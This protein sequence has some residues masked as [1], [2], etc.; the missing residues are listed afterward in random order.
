MAIL[1]KQNKTKFIH[2]KPQ[3]HGMY[4]YYHHLYIHRFQTASYDNKIRP[5]TTITQP[6][7]DPILKA[8][9]NRWYDKHG[10]D[11]GGESYFNSVF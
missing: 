6:K 5:N 1:P 3:K 10:F 9:R 2:K 8:L 11:I 7:A 4:K